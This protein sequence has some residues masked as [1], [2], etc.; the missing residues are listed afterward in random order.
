MAYVC[1]FFC[2]KNPLS[3]SVYTIYRLQ[4]YGVEKIQ[5]YREKKNKKRLF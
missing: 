4:K 3:G 5:K 2:S 1:L